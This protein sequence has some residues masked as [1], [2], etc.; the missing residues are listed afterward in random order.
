[1]YCGENIL[2]NISLNQIAADLHISPNHIS[3][4]FSKKLKIS[5]RDYI[6]NLRISKAMHLLTHTEKG[7]TEIMQEC[8]YT[9]QSTFN[10]TF[11]KISGTTPRQYRS[12]FTVVDLR[13]E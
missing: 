10:K 8:G 4:I 7:V 9:N 13:D 3:S 12:R 2:S 5:L 1:M 6:N 11:L